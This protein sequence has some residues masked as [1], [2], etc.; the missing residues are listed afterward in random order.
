M[1]LELRFSV[2]TLGLG[3]GTFIA[4]L[5]GMNLKN[6]I[7][8]SDA[9]FWGI[10]AIC[11][12]FSV[13]VLVYGLNRLRR[14]QRVSMWGNDCGPL[15]PA[16]IAARPT[17][18]NAHEMG[19]IFAAE[20][21]AAGAAG[22][23]HIAKMNKVKQ[24]MQDL[25]AQQLNPQGPLWTKAQQQAKEDAAAQAAQQAAKSARNGGSN[26]PQAD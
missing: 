22:K 9:G 24:K 12:V 19:Q 16:R 18:W 25:K 2:W 10:S 13:V 20:E 1:L 17:P 3:A 6:F 11:S 8:E 14:V 15:P 23:A 26:P 4:A 7:E 5:Y 21:R